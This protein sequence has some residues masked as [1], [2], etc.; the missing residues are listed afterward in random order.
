MKDTRSA[1]LSVCWNLGKERHHQ[2]R[3]GGSVRSGRTLGA[4]KAQ[5]PWCPTLLYTRLSS[6]HLCPFLPAGIGSDLSNP[7]ST[8]F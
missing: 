2:A 1:L 3:F 5:W 4:L 8:K 7:C 6:P